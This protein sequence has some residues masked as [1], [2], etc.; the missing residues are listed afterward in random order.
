MLAHSSI[1]GP[2]PSVVGEV[3]ILGQSGIGQ[4]F[5]HQVLGHLALGC[6]AS[7][8]GNGAGE[9]RWDFIPLSSV[10]FW[11][12]KV[13]ALCWLDG[14]EPLVLLLKPQ[15][16]SA[17]VMVGS[18]EHTCPSCAAGMSCWHPSLTGLMAQAS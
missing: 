1:Y 13:G 15:C 16:R 5:T 18:K 9:F 12:T 2:R 8:R 7:A 10:G 17:V 3:A 6:L 4:L 14:A 11:S